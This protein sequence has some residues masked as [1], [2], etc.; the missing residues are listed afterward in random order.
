ME[1]QEIS[2]LSVDVTAYVFKETKA[3]KVIPII[4]FGQN[5][6]GFMDALFRDSM[7]TPIWKPKCLR[8]RNA[9]LS[10]SAV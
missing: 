4:G 2:G 10:T 3:A 6:D 5:V 7:K 1:Y 8:R 9:D